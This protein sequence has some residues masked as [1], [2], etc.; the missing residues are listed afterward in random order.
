MVAESIPEDVPVSAP[1]RRRGGS[2]WFDIVFGRLLPAIFFSVF[3]VDKVLLVQASLDDLTRHRQPSDYLAALNQLLGLLYFTMLVVLYVVR[4]PKRAGDGR[5]LII[6]ASFFG[7]FSVILASFLPGVPIRQDLQG[8]STGMVLVGLGYTVWALA[9]LRRSFS[10]MPEAR[11]LVT[12]G[13]YGLSRH[14]LYLGEGTAAIGLNV[15]TVALP[16]LLVLTAF[17]IAQYIRIRA[18]ERVLEREFPEYGE[19]R[20]RVPRYLPTPA[21]IAR[22]L[23]R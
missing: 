7:S 14:P 6:L 19:Y 23:R 1:L 21:S 11:R 20:H 22:L 5:P 2:Y 17:L 15:P 3:I 13:P 8:F 4:L 16:G 10:I 18:E 9:Y 12:G